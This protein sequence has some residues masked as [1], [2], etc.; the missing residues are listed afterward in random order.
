MTPDPDPM[1]AMRRA[2]ARAVYHLLR[3]GVE[4]LKAVEAVL[5]ELGRSRKGPD[6]EDRPIRERVELE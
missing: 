2:G 1:D 4:G 5:E 6:E 3:A